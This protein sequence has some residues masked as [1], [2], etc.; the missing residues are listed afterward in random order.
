MYCIRGQV[1]LRSDSLRRRDGVEKCDEGV[2]VCQFHPQVSEYLSI[3]KSD[4]GWIKRLVWW[5]FCGMCG[6]IVSLIGYGA[7]ALWN[8]HLLAQTVSV[9]AEK[10]YRIEAGYLERDKFHD[11]RFERHRNM[12]DDHEKRIGDLEGKVGK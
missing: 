3:Q 2:R 12:L 6:I 8:Y 1:E 5:T 7:T 9:H 10:I 4:I 11:T